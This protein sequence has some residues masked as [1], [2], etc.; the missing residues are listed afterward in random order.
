M[1]QTIKG[2]NKWKRIL[3]LPLMCMVL[4]MSFHEIEEIWN[5]K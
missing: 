1:N 2:W 5:Q 4:D 3:L